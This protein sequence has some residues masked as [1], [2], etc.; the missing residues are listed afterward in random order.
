MGSR[1]E[2]R[3]LL[4]PNDLLGLANPLPVPGIPVKQQDVRSLDAIDI[5]NKLI[6]RGGIKVVGPSPT[7]AIRPTRRRMNK[8]IQ[9]G[10]D[11]L[12]N[13]IRRSRRSGVDERRNTDPLVE[14]RQ[15][16]DRSSEHTPF[17]QV[18]PNLRQR[19]H[20][21]SKGINIRPTSV[22]LSNFG[23]QKQPHGRSRRFWLE[24]P[25]PSDRRVSLAD[26][27]LIIFRRDRTPCGSDSH[28]AAKLCVIDTFS[29]GTT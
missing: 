28:R 12:P 20:R 16:F 22:F 1:Q 5:S 3:I 27:S 9:G 26:E 21:K 19:A 24:R 29:I 14:R 4:Q 6:K 8:R 25:H 2:K 11:T 15:Q 23:H 13:H 7:G 17:F 10:E 18:A